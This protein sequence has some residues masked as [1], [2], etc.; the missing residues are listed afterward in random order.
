MA[1]MGKKI[2][3]NTVNMAPIKKLASVFPF[4]KENWGKLHLRDAM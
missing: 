1:V 2:K 4:K 3:I